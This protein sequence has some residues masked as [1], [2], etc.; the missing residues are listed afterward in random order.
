MAFQLKSDAMHRIVV[1]TAKQ[2]CNASDFVG[3]FLL[4]VE[5]IL[6]GILRID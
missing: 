2:R 1:Y 6:K 4:K 3:Q 5:T